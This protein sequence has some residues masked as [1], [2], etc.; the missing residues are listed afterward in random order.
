MKA[1]CGTVRYFHWI[2]I[3]TRLGTT[4]VRVTGW[5]EHGDAYAK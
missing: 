2:M 5:N 3:L 4:G 1:H